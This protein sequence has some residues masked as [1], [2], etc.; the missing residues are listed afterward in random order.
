MFE[1][2]DPPPLPQTVQ[3]G[4]TSY[5]IVEHTSTG[6]VLVSRT[7]RDG[8]TEMPIPRELLDRYAEGVRMREAKQM[9]AE[10]MARMLGKPIPPRLF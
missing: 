4:K 9:L 10:F 8:V 7:N 5:R 3:R 2:V 6:F 1:Q